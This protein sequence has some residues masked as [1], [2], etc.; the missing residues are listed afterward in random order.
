MYIYIRPVAVILLDYSTFF[1]LLRDYPSS[2]EACYKE[3]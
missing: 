2:K 3:K 1:S